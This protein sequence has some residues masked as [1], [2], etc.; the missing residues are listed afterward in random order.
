[1]THVLVRHIAAF[2]GAFGLGLYLVPVMIVAAQKLQLYDMP[3]GKIKNHRAPVPFLGGLAIYV[4]FIIVLALIFPLETKLLWFLLGTTLLLFVGFVSLSVLVA[5]T[6]S[7][8][9]QI[10]ALLLLCVTA[11]SAA[12]PLKPSVFLLVS[13]LGGIS[14]LLRSILVLRLLA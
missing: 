1:M 13:A 5:L 4:S 3:D 6:V 12:S 9:I 14:S 10:S 8:S 2:V 7:A 11:Q